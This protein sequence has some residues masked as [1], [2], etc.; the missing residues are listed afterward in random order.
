MFLFIL[1]SHFFWSLLKIKVKL[2]QIFLINYE[3]HYCMEVACVE[4][5]TMLFH[6]KITKF[7]YF[8]LFFQL[9]IFV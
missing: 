8:C 5:K 2:K 6:E 3:A 7:E 1:L 9:I 4:A